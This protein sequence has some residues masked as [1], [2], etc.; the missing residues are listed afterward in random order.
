MSVWSKSITPPAASA[1]LPWTSSSLGI[2]PSIAYRRM[3]PAGSP[4]GNAATNTTRSGL[5]S[6][7]R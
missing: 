2:G 1:S 6:W 4:R 5:S 7:S 3:V